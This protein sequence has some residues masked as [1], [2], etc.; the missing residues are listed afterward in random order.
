MKK[1]SKKN[2][3]DRKEKIQNKKER[4]EKIQ[5]KRKLQI[6]KNIEKEKELENKKFEERKKKFA[7]FFIIWI[8]ILGMGLIRKTFQNDTFYTIEIGEL[9]LNNGIDMMDHFSFHSGLAYT[10]PHW[11][12]D[13]FIYLCYSI[14][15]YVG[16]H[17]STIILL[18]ILLVLVFKINKTI[19]DSVSVS[20][21]ATFI[22]ALSVSGF[23]TAR[24]QLASFLV[25]ALE[26]YFIE[27]FL[28]DK[29]KRYLI[30]LLVLSILICNIHLAVWPFYFIVYLP[31]L[32]EY[33][34]S[35][36]VS[37]I[38]I[39]KETKFIKFLKNKFVLEKNSNIKYLFLVMILSLFTGLLTPL[40]DTPYT[41]T[42]H[43][44][45]SNAQEYVK[46]HQMLSWAQSPFT[47]IIAGET[48]F[49]SLIS[50]VK[51]RDLFMICGLVLMSII[52]IRH[53]SLLALI[54]TIC[55][56]RLFAMF[57]E[58]YGFNADKIIIN[59]FSKKSVAI[60]SFVLVIIGSSLIANF[61]L[62]KDFVD[63]EMYPVG[64]VE[65]IKE[66]I[67]IDEMRIFNEYNFGSYLLHHDIP[68]FI[69]SRADLYTSE[70]SGFEYDIF[71]DYHYMPSHY[72]EKFEFY[73]ITHV[74]IYKEID[75]EVNP[76]YNILENDSNY[77]TLYEDEYYVLYEK[78]GTSDFVITY[79]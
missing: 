68:V 5:N 9:I 60:A 67:N 19:S 38:K 42:I 69:D 71:D 14:G 75:D 62:S 78:L 63:E 17:I 23:A 8:C 79:N 44:M 41:Y 47:I 39:K 59:F 48:L 6:E 50:K 12:Y 32:A 35:L 57:L 10:Y 58:N 53:L 46:E 25:F 52:S 2:S 34:I 20:A 37:K 1:G 65:Y 31:Y 24:A 54:G 27:M 16:I 61:Q 66:N 30:G 51:L 11:L 22:C 64:A 40:G 21:F 72:Q 77:K 7:W 26:I 55:F 36:I 15:G 73:G 28:R 4:N 18:L 13:V 49:L 76:F 45:M 29:K 33:I 43:M 70:Y 74:L 56:C 3:K